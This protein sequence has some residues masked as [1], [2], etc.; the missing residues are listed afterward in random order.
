MRI[1]YEDAAL[2]VCVKPVG[3][4]C[5]HELPTLLAAAL[6][7]KAEDYFCVHRLDR[8]VGGVMVYART[9]ESAAA[10]SRQVQQRTLQKE[11][12]AVCSGALVPADGEMRDFLYKDALKGRA[13]AVKSS[14]RGVKEAVLR[15]KTLATAPREE[16]TVSLVHVRLQTGRFHQIRCQFAARQHPLLGDGKYGSRVSGCTTALWSAR[17][18]FCHPTGGKAL[19][20]SAPPPVLFPWTLFNATHFSDVV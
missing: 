4:E 2:V 9:V 17:L 13:Y 12:L 18:G 6:G 19:H 5:E 3:A 8:A 14:R 20:F 15:Y 16:T 10:L 11:Y 1:L 7:G